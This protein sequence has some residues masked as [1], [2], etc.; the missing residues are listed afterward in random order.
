[1]PIFLSVLSFLG[2]LT[3]DPAP[4][5]FRSRGR[6]RTLECERLDAEVAR[7]VRPGEIKEERV[8]GAYSERDVMLCRQ[9]LIRPGLRDPGD[10]ALLRDLEA[11]VSV[12]AS[13]VASVRADLADRTWLVE[14]FTV[15][16]QVGT[17]VTFALKTALMRES[18]RVS[19]RLPVLSAGDVEVITRMHPSRAYAAACRRWHATGQLGES[20]VLVA[21]ITRDPRETILHTGLCVDGGW[22]WLR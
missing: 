3:D 22:T 1:M 15:N 4:G 5:V 13:Q 6:A 8:R 7:S 21:Q 12:V 20:D 10:E 9:R 2:F 14:A 11:R 19:D 18:L 16:P 17:K